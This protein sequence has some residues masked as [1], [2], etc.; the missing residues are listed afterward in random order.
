M[1]CLISTQTATY[2]TESC[3]PHY[4]GVQACTLSRN[5]YLY[6]L[7]NTKVSATL[8]VVIWPIQHILEALCLQR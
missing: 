1:E 4:L 6:A 8:T 5:C 7:K 3:N 2:V